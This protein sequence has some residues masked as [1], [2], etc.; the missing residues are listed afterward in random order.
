M[1]QELLI[2]AFKKL[3]GSRIAEDALQEA[4]CRLW[5]KKFAPKDV[6]QAVGTLFVTGRN[7]QID[8]FR[9]SRKMQTVPLEDRQ[10]AEDDNDSAAREALFRKVEESLDSELTDIQ[11]IIIRKHE[12]DGLTLAQIADEL[13]MQPAAVRMQ[14]SRARKALRK[15]YIEKDGQD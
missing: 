6:S 1:A 2:E 9:K 5:S 3:K 13:S 8:E 12:Y 11:R 4:F 7:I 15:I 10:I 14:I